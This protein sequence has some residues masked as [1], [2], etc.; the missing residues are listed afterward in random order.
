MPNARYLTHG[1]RAYRRER[2]IA[3]YRASGNLPAWRIAEQFGVSDSLVRRI[4]CAAGVS[5][6]R[7]VQ[8]HRR[9]STNPQGTSAGQ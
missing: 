1:D 5:R 6:G 8:R 4:V 2:I 3:A 9:A 7:S